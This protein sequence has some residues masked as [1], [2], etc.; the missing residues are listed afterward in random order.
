MCLKVIKLLVQ[1]R[2]V[3]MLNPIQGYPKVPI[4]IS[5][6]FEETIDLDASLL[7]NT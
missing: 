4:V 2:V 5:C 7:E 1:L 3:Y 6:V